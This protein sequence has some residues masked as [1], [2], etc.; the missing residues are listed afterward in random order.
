VEH[1]RKA[2]QWLQDAAD[3]SDEGDAI[4]DA[5]AAAL[6]AWLNADHF[7]TPASFERLM[8]DIYERRAT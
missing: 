1:L 7:M 5:L 6:Q 8:K 2:I 4:G 3:H